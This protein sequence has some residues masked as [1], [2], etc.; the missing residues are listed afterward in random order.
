MLLTGLMA[1]EL[2]VRSL[3]DTFTKVIILATLTTL[4]PYAFAA[5]AQLMQ[6]F[7]DQ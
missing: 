7:N 6:M 3:T 5:A 4:V 2:P 1:H